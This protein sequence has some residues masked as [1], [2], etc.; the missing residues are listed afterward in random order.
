[1]LMFKLSAVL[2]VTAAACARDAQPTTTP[3]AASPAMAPPGGHQ[4]PP[5]SAPGHEMHDKHAMHQKMH[6][7]AV[8]PGAPTPKPV[9]TAIAVLQPT[10]GNT[11]TGMVR[12]RDAGGA[13][14][15]TADVQGLP[16][17]EHAYHVHVFGDCSAPDGASAGPHFHFT[18]SSFD[19]TVKMITGDLGE[20]MGQGG[21][22]KQSARIA[23]ASLHGPFSIIGRAVVVHEKGNNPQVTPDGG[24][25]K[26]IACG[27]IGVAQTP[28]E[29]NAVSANP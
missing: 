6:S 26:R 5:G 25:G 18:G 13:L 11:V 16:P 15:V 1:M 29:S 27:V 22:V 19:K 14:E 12:F 17:G 24:A 3:V 2:L 8:D 23:G 4:H 9:A 20:L 21:T 28:V 10:S 7:V